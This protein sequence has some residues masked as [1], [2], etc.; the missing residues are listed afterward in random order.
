MNVGTPSILCID[1]EPVALSHLKC[2][3]S[4]IWPKAAASFFDSP[5]LALAAQTRA[6]ADI[7]ICDLSEGP[8]AALNLIE[9]MRVTAPHSINILL[10]SD[11]DLQSALRVMNDPSVFRFFSKP[12]EMSELKRAMTEAATEINL[13]KMRAISGVTLEA[14]GAIGAAVAFVDQNGALI[15]ANNGAKEML[16]ESEIFDFSDQSRFVIRNRREAARFSKHL[17]YMAKDNDARGDK[18]V[19]R[20]QR[21]SSPIPVSVSILCCSK[22]PTTNPYFSLVFSDPARKNITNADAIAHAL[23]LTPSEARIV[24]GLAEGAN[25]EDAAKMAGVS[26]STARTYIKNVFSKTGVSR[27]AELVRLALLSV[28]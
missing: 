11:P 8:K 22:Q 10:S 24:C 13:R 1:D 2:L 23:S 26:L 14:V 19:L 3:I 12:A 7:V 15:Y 21:E 18:V 16:C 27:Q 4:D 20:L 28:A 6:P 25:V 17:K 5:K 9:E